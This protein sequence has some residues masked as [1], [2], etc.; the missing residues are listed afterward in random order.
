[1]NEEHKTKLYIIIGFFL[2]LLALFYLFMFLG[3]KASC[4]GELIKARGFWVC[5]EAYKVADCVNFPAGF[6]L[7]VD[8]I[9][10]SLAK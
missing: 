5:V 2:I 7:L 4:S 6:D 3:A 10:F 8:Q 1:L 9:N